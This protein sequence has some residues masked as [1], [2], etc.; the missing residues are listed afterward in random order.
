[1]NAPD[2]FDF[3][4]HQPEFLSGIVTHYEQLLDLGER[5]G[6][7]VCAEFLK[8]VKSVGYTFSYGLDGVP[9]DLRLL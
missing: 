8:V 4:E 7:Q 2:L 6:Y 3:H 9:Y 5:D 1:M